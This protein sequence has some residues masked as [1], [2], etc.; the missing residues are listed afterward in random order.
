M[1]SGRHSQLI[2]GIDGG[3][4][5]TLAL[6]ADAALRVLGRGTAGPSNY[7]G[8]GIAAAAAALEH[9]IAAATAD[10]GLAAPTFTAACLGMA[11]VDRPEDRALMQ[12]WAD[13]WLPGVPLVIVNDAQLVLAA[14]TPA[15]WGVGLICG[16]GSIAYGQNRAGRWARA[17]GWGHL[18]GDEGSGYAVGQAALRAVMRAFDGRAPA[19]TLTAAVLGHWGLAAPPD[20]VRRVYREPVTPADLAA[21]APLVEAAAAAGDAVADAILADAG[22]ELAL[23]VAAVIH[24]LN[25]PSPVPCALAGGL[26][27]KGPALRQHFLAA[28]QTSDLDLAPVTPV[29][30]PAQGA[31]RLAKRLLTPLTQKQDAD[32]RG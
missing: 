20:L 26:L 25:L 2:L 27:V 6:V 14:G 31:L 19:T 21:L 22:H 3:G 9:A 1:I 7:Q 32:E 17:G 24:A 16:T 23:A 30:E 28:A 29:T 18:L 15:G 10:A 8:V 12:A 11:G 5:K 4:S 13:R